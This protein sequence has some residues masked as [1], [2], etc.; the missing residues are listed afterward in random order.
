MIPFLRKHKTEN[1][2]TQDFQVF[3]NTY[4]KLL[5][6]VLFSSFFRKTNNKNLKQNLPIFLIFADHNVKK[7]NSFMKAINFYGIGFL[8]VD[9][10]NSVKDTLK[11]F[12]DLRNQHQKCMK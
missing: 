5:V 8:G 2:N 12:D 7:L 9:L 11:A 3:C 10:E 1:Y 6:T 4:R